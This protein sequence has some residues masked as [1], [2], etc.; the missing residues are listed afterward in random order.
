MYHAQ[1]GGTCLKTCALLV[2]ANLLYVY[3]CHAQIE[4]GMHRYKVSCTNRG[5]HAQIKGTSLNTCTQLVKANP[6]L[7]CSHILIDMKPSTDLN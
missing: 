3:T 7:L 6:R 2:K 4:G 5:C 1:I